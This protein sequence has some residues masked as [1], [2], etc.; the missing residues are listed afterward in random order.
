MPEADKI[1]SQHEVDA[2]LSAIDSGAAEPVAEP[3]AEPYDFRRPSRIPPV[4]LRYIQSM[5]EGF[6]RAVQSSLAALLLR[7]VETRLVGVHQLPLGEFVSSQPHP[8]VLILAS[9]APLEGNFLVALNPSIAYPL[10]ERLLGAGKVAPSPRDRAMSPLEWNV[11]DALTARLLDLLASAWS[12]LAPVRFQ[13]LRRE[14]DPEVLKFDSPNEPSV[15]ITLEL[16]MGDQRGPLEIV[17]PSTTVEPF[18]AKMASSASFSEVKDSSQGRQ[19]AISRRLAPAEVDLSAELP[20]E[21]ARLE[22]FEDLRPGDLLVTRHPHSGPVWITIEGRLKFLARLG[23]LKH[24]KAVRIAEERTE[25]PQRDR[26]AAA[27]GLIKM[28][29]GD[30]K[31]SSG[32][33]SKEHLLRLPLVGSVVLAEKTLCVGEVLALRIGDVVEFSH[34]VEDPLELRVSGAAIAEG[35]AVKLGDRFGIRLTALRDP[36]GASGQKGA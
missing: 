3:T 20:P 21:P 11:T 1:L 14:S 16:T 30:R 4:P 18:F 6:A 24:R 33:A 2:L 23:S 31:S 17:F 10:L 9:A 12:V 22:L 27:A 8:S 36:R 25:P 34:R 13:V 5:H 15:A 29:E 26:G 32:A 7:P 28:A 19:E 35:V